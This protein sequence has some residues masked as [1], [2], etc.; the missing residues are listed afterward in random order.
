MPG[1]EKDAS[2]RDEEKNDR[3]TARHLVPSRRR[4]GDASA[5]VPPDRPLTGDCTVSNS[6]LTLSSKSNLLLLVGFIRVLDWTQNCKKGYHTKPS[7]VVLY[8]ALWA[9][10]S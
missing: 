8:G 4:G 2:T 10:A 5:G 7:F 9:V 6:R 1:R 3:G